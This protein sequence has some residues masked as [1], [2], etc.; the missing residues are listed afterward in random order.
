METKRFA[1]VCHGHKVPVKRRPNP[2]ELTCSRI[3]RYLRVA[4]SVK[5]RTVHPS[6]QGTTT[7]VPAKSTV[8]FIPHV[9]IPPRTVIQVFRD[10]CAPELEQQVPPVGMDSLSLSLERARPELLLLPNGS[11]GSSAC[12]R[13]RG[14][15]ERTP[16]IGVCG[17]EQS[18]PGRAPRASPDTPTCSYLSTRARC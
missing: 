17:T 16:A 14:S 12:H 9:R 3:R 2:T 11:D 7:A 10:T 15:E 18:E 8:T 6:L 13:A 1:E 5:S 4:C